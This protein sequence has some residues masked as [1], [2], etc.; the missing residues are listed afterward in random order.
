MLAYIVATFQLF[1]LAFAIH[2]IV[3]YL[4]QQHR[5]QI[6]TLFLF[7]FVTV[8][9]ILLRLYSAIWVLPTTH[10]ITYIAV[11]LPLVNK[12]VIGLL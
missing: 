8:T 1:L 9:D 10:N 11:Y 5:C 4:I 12:F 3:K 2:N 7:Y 6:M